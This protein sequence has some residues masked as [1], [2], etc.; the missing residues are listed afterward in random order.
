MCIR[1]RAQVERASD[2]AGLVLRQDGQSLAIT[3][4]DGAEP[5]AAGRWEVEPYGIPE[6]FYGGEL[7]E[8]TR[9]RWLTQADASGRVGI[10]V[11]LRPGG[12]E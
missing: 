2:T 11:T 1:D 7:P 12:G 4:G 9:L 6:G 3:V 8:V 10:R 5:R